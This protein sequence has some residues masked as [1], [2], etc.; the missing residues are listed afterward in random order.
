MR[1]IVTR[2]RYF[3]IGPRVPC[4]ACRMSQELTRGASGSKGYTPSRSTIRA[5]SR[6]NSWQNKSL[7]TAWKQHCGSARCRRPF[8]VV[9]H[10]AVEEDHPGYLARLL[11]YSLP[12]VVIGMGQG[13][14]IQG[15][16]PH[17]VA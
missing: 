1:G 8:I 10:A 3:C 5:N 7:Q 12:E 6:R 16:R 9:I 13:Q 14:E 15:S 4:G 2:V 11:A 17:E